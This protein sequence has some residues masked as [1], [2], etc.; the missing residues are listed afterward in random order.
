MEKKNQAHFHRAAIVSP[1]RVTSFVKI[2]AADRI[3]LAKIPKRID[4]PFTGLRVFVKPEFCSRTLTGSLMIQ[5]IQASTR[6]FPNRYFIMN[7]PHNEDDYCFCHGINLNFVISEM[8]EINAILYS[9]GT[10]SFARYS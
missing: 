7:W 1:V 9:N 6:G 5:I 2:Q 8:F 10:S 3:K 4:V